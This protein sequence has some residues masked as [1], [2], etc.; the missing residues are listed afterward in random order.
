VKALFRQV[1]RNDDDATYR[2]AQQVL[3]GEHRWLERGIAGWK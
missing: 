3:K 2:V 1:F